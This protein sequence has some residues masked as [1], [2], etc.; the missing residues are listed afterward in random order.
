ME[1]GEDGVSVGLDE[2][3]LLS[4]W[5]HNGCK[6]VAHIGKSGNQ[7]RTIDHD[8]AFSLL[9]TITCHVHFDVGAEISNTYVHRLIL[10]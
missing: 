6:Q 2:R 8:P 9:M 4:S 5:S 7:A 3:R 1:N 10:I